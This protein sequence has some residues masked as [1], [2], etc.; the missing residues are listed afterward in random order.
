MDRT[1]CQGSAE[2]MARWKLA[3]R[4]EYAFLYYA[5]GGK[6]CAQS[7]RAEESFSTAKSLQALR[8]ELQSGSHTVN[9]VEHTRGACLVRSGEQCLPSTSL[10]SAAERSKSDSL[11]SSTASAFAVNIASRRVSIAFSGMA[12]YQYSRLASC[13]RRIKRGTYTNRS[14]FVSEGLNRCLEHSAHEHRQRWT[15]PIDKCVRHVL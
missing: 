3:Y 14:P 13:S 5:R 8:A 4:S 2:G 12:T 1:R 15:Q 9:R 10:R 7:W 11:S 6:E